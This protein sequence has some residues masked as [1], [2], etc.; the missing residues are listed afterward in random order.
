[1]LLRAIATRFYRLVQTRRGSLLSLGQERLSFALYSPMMGVYSAAEQCTVS[2]ISKSMQ[3]A[4]LA[5][6][7]TSEAET[8][9][10][11]FQRRNTRGHWLRRLRQLRLL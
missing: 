6:W 4:Q 9:S 8:T 3:L 7:R 2:K 11:A 10:S 1:M 5:L